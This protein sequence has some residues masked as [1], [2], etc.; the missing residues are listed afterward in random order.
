MMEKVWLSWWFEQSIK[1]DNTMQ[2]Y[3]QRGLC[4]AP[5]AL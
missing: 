3:H 2:R 1:A 5:A 4:M